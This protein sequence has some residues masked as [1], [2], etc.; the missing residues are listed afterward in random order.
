MKY[1]KNSSVLISLVPWLAS[2]SM[3]HAS[4][5]APLFGQAR[6]LRAFSDTLKR[7]IRLKGGNPSEA[8]VNPDDPAQ[9]PA[10]F[11]KRVLKGRFEPQFVLDR[12]NPGFALGQ[13][14]PGSTVTLAGRKYREF[15]N[16]TALQTIGFW[17]VQMPA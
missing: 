4:Q 15:T 3:V 1:L 16:S 5:K 9:S 14:K 11:R 2:V 10:F 17:P 13:P 7:P 12:E 6:D 8:L